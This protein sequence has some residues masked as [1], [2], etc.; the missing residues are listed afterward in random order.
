M[1]DPLHVRDEQS[2]D[3]QAI[4]DVHV[5]AFG[6]GLEARLVDLLRA[7]GK[8]TIGLVGC[9]NDRVVGH[10]LFSPITIADAPTDFRGAAL[11]PVG[12]LPERQPKGIGSTL[13]REGLA[14]CERE[15]Y[16]LV[17]LL[18]HVTYYPRFGFK[19]CQGFRVR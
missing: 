14:R 15:G 13:I 6:R 8:A 12:V 18:G 5:H 11:G 10:I 4:H 9:E 19:A 16:D 3:E 2:G 17:I 7:A 1:S